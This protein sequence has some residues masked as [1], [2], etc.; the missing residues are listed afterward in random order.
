M[1]PEKN[2]HILVGHKLKINERI[3]RFYKSNTI[4]QF[5]DPNPSS[6][7]NSQKNK[8][9]RESIFNKELSSLNVKPVF[10]ESSQK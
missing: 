1:I 3:F 6:L 8:S 2:K 9:L 7:V 10:K 5:I 4:I